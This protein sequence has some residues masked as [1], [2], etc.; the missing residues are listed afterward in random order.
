M[1]K[2]AAISSIVLTILLAGFLVQGCERDEAPGGGTEKEEHADE[3]EQAHEEEN[4]H[5]DEGHIE[6][7]PEAL[8][9]ISL[10]TATAERRPVGGEIKTTAVIEPDNTRIAHV[11]PRIPGRVSSVNAFLGDKVTKGQVLAE[12]DSIELG[13]AKSEYL[14]ARADLEVARANFSREERL[15]GRQITSEKEYLDAKGEFLRAEAAL[16]TSAET[17]RLLGLSDA[18]VKA[19]SWTERKSPPSIF[20]LKAPFDGTIIEKHTVLGELI[21]PENN[22]Y[23]IADLTHLWIQLDVY[24][25]DLRH[26]SKG[27]PV[28]VTVDAYPGEKFT[29]EVTY[30][31]D[32]LDE[33]TRTA[34]ARVEIENED[35]RLKPGMF[36]SA[37]ITIPGEGGDALTVPS[38][39][40]QQVRGK[41]TV[42]VREG[43]GVF[44]AK[45]I[46]AGREAGGYVEILGGV[47]PGDEVVTEGGFYLKSLMLK[48]EMGEGHAH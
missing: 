43:E 35:G 17:L 16:N 18:D 42:F 30:V 48:D 7:T 25:K 46:T 4:G 1:K 5:E 20:P 3:G 36:A 45:E 27:K 38:S 44:E 10:K 28:D 41:P 31:S 22:A 19:I 32:V 21:S 33:S 26:V 11:T 34:R 23:T 2:Y 37:L 39:A 6:L 29:G 12:L 15:Y 9:S 13:Q 47:S 14:K 24:E 40:V 8:E